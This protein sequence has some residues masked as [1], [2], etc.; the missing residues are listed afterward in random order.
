MWKN[1]F[2]THFSTGFPPRKIRIILFFHAFSTFL[3]QKNAG[4]STTLWKTLC[5]I[6][7]VFGVFVFVLFD[8]FYNIFYCFF[9][10]FAKMLV[11][12]LIFIYNYI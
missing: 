3:K 8:V 10:N 4:F 6:N 7:T 2:F 9:I 5:I 11:F 12:E 1:T